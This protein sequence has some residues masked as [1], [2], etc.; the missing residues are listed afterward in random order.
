MHEDTIS[1]LLRRTY[2]VLASEDGS[3]QETH[4]EDEKGSYVSKKP[5]TDYTLDVRPSGIR[6]ANKGCF[7]EFVTRHKHI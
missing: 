5:N 3:K 6:G 1:V 2:V 7:N 4:F